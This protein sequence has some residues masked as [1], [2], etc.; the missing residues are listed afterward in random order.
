MLSNTCKD[1]A[2]ILTIP[3]ED[4]GYSSFSLNRRVAS[5]GEKLSKIFVHLDRY[6]FQSNPR[7]K[8]EKLIQ[9][10]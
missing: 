1:Q 10:L 7:E 2:M 4:A 6:H 5:S 8:A 3:C 9:H